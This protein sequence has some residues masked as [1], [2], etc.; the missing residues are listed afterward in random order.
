MIDTSTRWL[1]FALT[2]GSPIA[3]AGIVTIDQPMGVGL[4]DTVENLG[5]RQEVIDTQPERIFDVKDL[6]TGVVKYAYFSDTEKPAFDGE[7]ITKRTPVSWVKTQGKDRNG[8]DLGENKKE[9]TMYSQGAFVKMNDGKWREIEFAT[10][11][12][13]KFLQKESQTQINRAQEVGMYGF[14]NTANAQTF[15][16]DPNPETNTF[17]GYVQNTGSSYST[18]RGAS[19]GGGASDTDNGG[20]NAFPQHSLFA[21]TYYIMRGFFLFDTS[22]IADGDTVDTATFSLYY[23]GGSSDA[24]NEDVH[25][26]SST[27]ASNTSV[28]TDDYDQTGG[29]SF[30][31]MDLAGTANAYNDISV[32]ST[33]IA[34]ISKTG[35]TK[36]GIK[37]SGDLNN[38]APTGLN[39]RQIRFAD[40]TGTT[41]DPKLVVTVSTPSASSATSS[42][43]FVIKGGTYH[44]RSG[45]LINTQM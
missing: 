42:T 3:F 36:F 34:T 18:V 11:T 41:Y 33:G 31:S 13:T 26:V 20:G 32:N 24:D 45:T 9:V 38:T 16:P 37:N 17:D 27:P 12:K 22:S 40:Y 30:G 35:I 7:D 23:D 4:V 5:A 6:K 44:I 14:I 39:Q 1:L 21:G 43:P 28:S 8:E 15:Y 2:I 19:A 25:L 29:T 10:T